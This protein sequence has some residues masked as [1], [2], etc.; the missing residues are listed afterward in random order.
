M[1]NV[2]NLQTKLQTLLQIKTENCRLSAA[3]LRPELAAQFAVESVLS[4]LKG[5][6][7]YAEQ[8]LDEEIED[9]LKAGR[10]LKAQH[11]K[12]QSLNGL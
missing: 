6:P 1:Q 4:L 5:Q 11:E 9:A 2:L 12:R 8:L 3:C 10:Q 7:Q